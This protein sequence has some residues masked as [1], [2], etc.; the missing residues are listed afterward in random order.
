MQMNLK[1]Y[2]VRFENGEI[3][4]LESMDITDTQEGIVIF[5]DINKEDLISPFFGTL[6]D[7]LNVDD[8]VEYINNIRNKLSYDTDGSLKSIDQLKNEFKD[9]N[10]KENQ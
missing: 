2:K 4:P 6:K 7:S 8:S 9:L 3:K 1:Q 10:D 5:F